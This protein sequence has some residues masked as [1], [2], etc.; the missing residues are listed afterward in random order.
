ML[1]AEIHNI[2]RYQRVTYFGQEKTNNYREKFIEKCLEV[3]ENIL[4]FATRN[5]EEHVPK[6]RLTYIKFETEIFLL[7]INNIINN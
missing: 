2:R 1:Y 7:F 4:T 5:C 3:K 6:S